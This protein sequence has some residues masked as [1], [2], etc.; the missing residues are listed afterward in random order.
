MAK[1]AT[2]VAPAQFASV[3]SRRANKMLDTI[4][5]EEISAAT[6]TPIKMKGSLALFCPASPSIASLGMVALSGFSNAIF[7]TKPNIS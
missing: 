5:E 2:E 6:A 4:P 7:A 1:F 3:I